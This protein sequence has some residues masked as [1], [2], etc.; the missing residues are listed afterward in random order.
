MIEFFKHNPFLQRL[1]LMP[2]NYCYYYLCRS[3][4][5]VQG[6]KDWQIIMAKELIECGFNVEEK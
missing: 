4:D 2:W 1:F 6:I 5:Y 3:I